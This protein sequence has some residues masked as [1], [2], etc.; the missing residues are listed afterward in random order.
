MC[1]RDRL[2]TKYY[3]EN[4]YQQNAQD[5]TDAPGSV[6]PRAFE[7]KYDLGGGMLAGTAKRCV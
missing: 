7:I 1:I 3:E 6:V 4:I 2:D 5:A